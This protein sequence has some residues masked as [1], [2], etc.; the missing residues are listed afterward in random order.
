MMF[1]LCSCRPSFLNINLPSNASQMP[2]FTPTP[3]APSDPYVN[4]VPSTSAQAG[5]MPPNGDAWKCP[6]W[7]IQ[8]NELKQFGD[9]RRT[10]I[11]RKMIQDTDV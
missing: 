3:M 10:Q 5:F 4:C 6:D 8:S 7:L 1:L 11:K 9:V 2:V